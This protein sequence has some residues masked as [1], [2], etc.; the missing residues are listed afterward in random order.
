MICW[1]IVHASS[2]DILPPILLTS[3]TLRCNRRVLLITCTTLLEIAVWEFRLFRIVGL[4]RGDGLAL[5][6]GFIGILF[7]HLPRPLS[8]IFIRFL[9]QLSNL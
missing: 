8:F 4:L 9:L 2:S 1:K 7:L 3:C 5:G 6:C